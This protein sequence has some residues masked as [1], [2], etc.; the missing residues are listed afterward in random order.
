MKLLPIDALYRNNISPNQSPELTAEGLKRCV[1]LPTNLM[2][3]R[4]VCSNRSAR[5]RDVIWQAKPPAEAGGF[6]LS[7]S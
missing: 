2:G 1:L 3:N 7:S 6:I 4:S 5:N